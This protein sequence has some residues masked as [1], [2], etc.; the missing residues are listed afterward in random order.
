MYLG[1]FT[2]VAPL[3]PMELV[4]FDL[5]TKYKMKLRHS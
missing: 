1:L 4:D 5:N 3:P 2:L